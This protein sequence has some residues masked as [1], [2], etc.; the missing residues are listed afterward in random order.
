[1]IET[2]ELRSHITFSR[3]SSFN[4]TVIV[5][6]APVD[7]RNRG[8]QSLYRR[9]GTSPPKTR[10]I[11]S[12]ALA[13]LLNLGVSHTGKLFKRSRPSLAVSGFQS[14]SGPTKGWEEDARTQFLAHLKRMLNSGRQ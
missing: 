6:I 5:S 14:L 13:D 7:H 3:A 2:G 11:G 9:A 4:D 8:K 12:P 10:V 1:P